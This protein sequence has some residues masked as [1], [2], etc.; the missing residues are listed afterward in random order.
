MLN[1]ILQ[2][3]KSH[4]SDPS[5]KGNHR[6]TVDARI[7]L[8]GVARDL[9]HGYSEIAKAVGRDRSTVYYYEKNCN[10]AILG[11]KFDL[12]KIIFDEVRN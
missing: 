1:T 5:S 4:L 7:V 12:V 8:T 9:G 11:E 6:P 10:P 2:S 3:V